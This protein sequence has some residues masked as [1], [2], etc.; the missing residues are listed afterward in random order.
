MTT[1]S[2]LL[3]TWPEAVC[4]TIFPDPACVGAPVLIVVAVAEYTVAATPSN[5]TV[6]PDATGLKFVPVMVTGVSGKPAVGVKPEI[7]GA[8]VVS[9]TVNEALLVALPEGELTL[10]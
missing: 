3:V 10:I 7:V 1:K 5:V 8:P 9:V 6:L 2:P 4:T